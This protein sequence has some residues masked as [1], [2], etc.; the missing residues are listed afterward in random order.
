MAS[1][2]VVPGDASLQLPQE[3][4]KQLIAVATAAKADI[5]A[6]TIGALGIQ[7]GTVTLVAGVGTVNTGIVVTANSKVFGFCNTPGAGVSGARYVAQDADLVVG[8]AGV[9]T[10]VIRAMS[11][12]NPAVAVTTDVSTINYLIVN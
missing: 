5:N 3:A 1:T 11:T 2:I 6:I 4:A 12:A 8:A 7:V 10:I 9:G